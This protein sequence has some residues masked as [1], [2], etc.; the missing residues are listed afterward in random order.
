MRSAIKQGRTIPVS[1]WYRSSSI[2][3]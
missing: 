2:N 1:Y 3:V